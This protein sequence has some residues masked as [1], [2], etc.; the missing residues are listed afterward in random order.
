MERMSPF[1]QGITDIVPKVMGVSLAVSR[2]T[3]ITT[4]LKVG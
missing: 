2:L 4:F 3:P 1:G